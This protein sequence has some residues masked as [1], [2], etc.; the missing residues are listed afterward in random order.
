MWTNNYDLTKSR[1]IFSWCKVL[2]L[3][4]NFMYKS[5]LS[6]ARGI[7]HHDTINNVCIYIFTI[8]YSFIN[9]FNC[10]LGASSTNRASGLGSLLAG[11]IGILS[12]QMSFNNRGASSEA[13]QT[14]R[15]GRGI[16]TRPTRKS[17][18]IENW[19]VL[20]QVGG[21]CLTAL[22]GHTRTHLSIFILFC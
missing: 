19:P 5:I 11:N 2:E 10:H 13:N 9:L 18:I 7:A 12:P 1:L 8:I 20:F 17:W 14:W 16:I 4:K 6:E 22:I 15:H 21:F 3:I